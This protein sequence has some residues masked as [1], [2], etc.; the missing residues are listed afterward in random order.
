MDT[1]I[2]NSK[3]LRSSFNKEFPGVVI[4]NCRI[5]A[6]GSFKF[7]LDKEEEVKDVTRQWKS[8]SFGGNQGVSSPAE[9][10]TSGIIKHVYLD[11]SEEQLTEELKGKYSCIKKVEL[12]KKNNNF[13]GTIKLIFN[14]RQELLD[15]LT[16]RIKIFNQRYI[17]EEYKPLPRVIKCNRCQTF[18]HIA[19]RC[20]AEK[21]TCGKCGEQTHETMNCSS[22]VKKCAHCNEGHETGHSTCHVMKT[23]LDEIRQRAQYG[24]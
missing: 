11:N 14:T 24:F 12:F 9:M 23:K 8:D 7:E 17:M 4:K 10:H 20:R 21:P 6:G 13:T 2:T 22:S 18:G 5:T 19:R 3:T 16:D 15:C 1:S